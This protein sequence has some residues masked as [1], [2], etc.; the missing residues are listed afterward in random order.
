MGPH[1]IRNTSPDHL[2]VDEGRDLGI[3]DGLP[4]D[5]GGV[6]GARGDGGVDVGEVSFR[7]QLL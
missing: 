6:G 4:G 1:R 2:V 5:D 7:I 3:G